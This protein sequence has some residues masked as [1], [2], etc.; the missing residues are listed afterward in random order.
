MSARKLCLP[1]YRLTYGG[2]RNSNTGPPQYR[3]LRYTRLGP[4]TIGGNCRIYNVGKRTGENPGGLPLVL[5]APNRIGPVWSL[6]GGLPV[7]ITGYL[8]AKH[9]DWTSRLSTTRGRRL[10]D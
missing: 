4:D 8:N 1:P 3:Q 6:S 2:R 5:T 7:L 9:M 10:R